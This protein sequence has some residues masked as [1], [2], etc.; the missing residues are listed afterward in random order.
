M[1]L[2]PTPPKPT[3]TAIPTFTLSPTVTPAPVAPQVQAVAVSSLTR[4]GATLTWTT[5][6]PST[7]QVEFGTSALDVSRS[8]VDASL[9]TV[10]RSVVTGLQAGTTYRY[11]VRSVSASGGLGISAEG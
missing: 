7:S 10:H 1:T 8:P 3:V 2:T 11:R 5:D 6:A 4:S 9:V